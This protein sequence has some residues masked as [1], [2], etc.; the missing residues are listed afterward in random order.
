MKLRRLLVLG[1]LSMTLAAAPAV[2]QTVIKL[3]T[4]TIND[5]QHEY[6]KRLAER[7]NK[8]LAGKVKVEVYPAEQ[9]ARQRTD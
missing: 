3:G 4:A 6:I 8:Q 5:V 9:L 1:A 2:A 7:M